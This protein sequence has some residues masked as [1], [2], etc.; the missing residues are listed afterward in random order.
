MARFLDLPPE[1]R[2]LVYHLVLAD[3]TRVSHNVQPTN[4]HLRLLRLCR[5][6][7]AESEHLLRAYVSLRSEYQIINFLR[8]VDIRW[9]A[10]VKW[11]DVA[12]DGRVAASSDPTLDAVPLSHLF[13]ALR[14]FTALQHLRVFDC[15][16]GS[17]TSGS[18]HYFSLCIL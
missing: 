18:R 2:L 16:I 11:A 4:T 9:R 15:R 5:I 13:V 10:N 8:S 6:V 1:I 12:N 14:D 7:R 3:H 17:S